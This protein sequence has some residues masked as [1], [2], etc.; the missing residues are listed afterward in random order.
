V[1]GKRFG[2]RNREMPGEMRD[3]GREGIASAPEHLN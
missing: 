1:N 2:S 3:R